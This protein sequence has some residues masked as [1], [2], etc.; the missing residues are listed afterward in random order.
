M[1]RYPDEA[2]AAVGR[3]TIAATDLE[4]L[5]AWIGA[6][7]AGGDATKVFLKP[8]EPLSAARGSVEFA[9]STYRSAYLHAVAGAGELLGESQAVL[10]DTW[11]QHGVENDGTD[12]T[13]LGRATSVRHPA[14][15][16]VLDRLTARL[17]ECRD[18]LAALLA[19]Q[20]TR[21]PPE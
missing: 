6:D 11:L 12:W 16:T 9:P 3:L 7:Q 14:D 17:L 4:F 8:G 5:L 10:R 19:A 20:L 1:Q 21:Q 13:V 18:H 15:P 2:L